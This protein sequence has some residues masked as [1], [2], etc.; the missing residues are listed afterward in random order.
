MGLGRLLLGGAATVD[1]EIILPEFLW[2]WDP[3]LRRISIINS[4]SSM[5]PLYQDNHKKERI[6][7]EKRGH[8]PQRHA[9]L[10][11][12]WLVV[13]LAGGTYIKLP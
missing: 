13:W 5:G 7:A 12:A 4:I 11:E 10:P 2:F 3:R 6:I 8:A 1:K 9:V